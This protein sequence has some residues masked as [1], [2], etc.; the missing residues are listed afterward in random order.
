MVWL[1]S[2]LSQ[3]QKI[4]SIRKPQREGMSDQLFAPNMQVNVFL[5]LAQCL[6]RQNPLASAPQSQ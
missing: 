6:D 5:A 3:P 2:F 1:F 4:C